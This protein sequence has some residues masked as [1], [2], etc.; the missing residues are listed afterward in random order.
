MFSE[1]LLAASSDSESV[2]IYDL[3]QGTYLGSLNNV[4]S[5]SQYSVAISSNEGINAN[6][7][8]PW[9]MSISTSIPNAQVYGLNWS[10]YSSKLR[11][12]LPEK[13]SCVA[14]SISGNYVY[15]G[16]LTGKIYVWNVNSGD[17]LKCWEAHYGPVTKITIS[18]DESVIISGGEDAN[19]HIWL[20]SRVVDI[21][22]GV[23]SLVPELSLSDHTMPITGISISSSSLFGGSFMSG[24]ARIFTSSKD[25]TIKCWQINHKSS[26]TRDN[27]HSFSI[28]SRQGNKDKQFVS[29][30]LLI[31][32]LLPSVVRCLAVNSTET[33]IYCGCLNG[34]VYQINVFA[35][36]WTGKIKGFY[37]QMA[38]S[39]SDE[40]VVVEVGLKG[41]KNHSQND[42]ASNHKNQDSDNDTESIFIGHSGSVNSISLSMDGSLLV[43][44]S[45]DSTVKIWDTLSKQSVRTISDSKLKESKRANLKTSLSTLI[46]KGI[47]QVHVMVR[48]VGYGGLVGYTNLAKEG[49]N[50]AISSGSSITDGNVLNSGLNQQTSQVKN[51]NKGA[52]KP[53]LQTNPFFS[54]LKRIPVSSLDEDKV[55]RDERASILKTTLSNKR[56][57]LIAV[58]GYAGT[59]LLKSFYSASATAIDCSNQQSVPGSLNINSAN[60]KGSSR[61][62]ELVEQ[63]AKLKG[64]IHEISGKYMKLKSLNDSLYESTVAELLRKNTGQMQPEAS[65]KNIPKQK[66]ILAETEAEPKE[67]KPK[68]KK[69][70]KRKNN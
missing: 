9:I 22:G 6:N 29:G 66:P 13:M 37:S 63:I 58:G 65:T 20:F 70:K 59:G 33:K 55:R 19:V 21:T 43:T 40:R 7:S 46:N 16:S 61:E 5:D 30:D 56:N 48:P 51:S 4:P 14:S 44:G 64:E 1:I 26:E 15:A 17:L 28:G 8:V 42:K 49:E 31:T 45:S 18:D 27:K 54:V 10:E 34:N 60:T 2:G 38:N 52:K 41:I 68:A 53:H 69:N 50:V 39:S 24:G 25:Q 57:S 3:R 11:F 12:P 47:S 35:G 32:W 36:F 23:G 62:D 67:V